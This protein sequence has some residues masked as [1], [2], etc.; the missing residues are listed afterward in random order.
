MGHERIG[1]LPKS[2]QWRDVVG[3]LS[4]L[5]EHPARV[6]SIASDTLGLVK[7]RFRA[8]QND[9]AVNSSFA[10]L[11]QIARTCGKGGL[12]QLVGS[13]RQQL[14]VKP[15][16]VAKALR[17]FVG[18]EISNAEYGVLAQDAAIDAVGKWYS[19]RD[20]PAQASL[21]SDGE[22][23]SDPW[24]RLGKSEGFCELSRLY[25]ASLSERYLNYFLER[26]VASALGSIQARQTVKED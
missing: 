19:L 1:G 11:I 8:L 9:S 26:E 17:D 7:N 24:A 23:S 10:F 21:F 14:E 13:T 3:G 4:T 25:F 15:I 18:N 16:T 22:I 5:Y 20:S 2:Q 12:P 6:D